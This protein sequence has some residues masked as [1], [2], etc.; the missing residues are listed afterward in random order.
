MKY[1]ICIILFKLISVSL[2]A[3]LKE[4]F[5][6]GQLE[7]G[8]GISYQGYFKRE[9]LKK[10]RKGVTFKKEF[11]DSVQ[12][13]AAS[14]IKEAKFE[15]GEIFRA[16]SY[17]NV[18]TQLEEIFL[19]SLLVDGKVSL[20]ETEFEDD[21]AYLLA[22]NGEYAW[23]QE[24]RIE[25]GSL[26]RFY[27]RNKLAAFLTSDIIS[28]SS[29][30]RIGFDEK[31]LIEIVSLHNNQVS[32]KNIVVK[33]SVENMAYLIIGF[34]GM[35]KNNNNKEY[36]VSA[37]YRSYFPAISQS[38]SLNI[39]LSYYYNIYT[40][41]EDKF[42]RQLYTL[43]LFIRQNILTKSIRPYIDV[44]LNLSYIEDRIFG[45]NLSTIPRGPQQNYGLGFLVGA[46][47]EMDIFKQ[48][49]IK[50]EYKFENYGHLLMVGVARVIKL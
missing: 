5:I 50:T 33:K 31:E 47:I 36:N 28:S 2:F 21:F 30:E 18:A 40:R 34:S 45:T 24:D 32:S 12:Y 26:R 11:S 10:I 8:N 20:Y 49:Q 15:T 17:L 44:G 14:D 19:A 13:Y 41:D 39:G 27:F 48:Y 7:L 43:P 25:D 23:L 29:F 4:T 16:I 46:G 35:H 6:K 37:V 42:K 9:A 3:Q 1:C 38:T 22:K